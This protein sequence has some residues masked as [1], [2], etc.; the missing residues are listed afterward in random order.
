MP[1]ANK[2]LKLHN[3]Q[4]YFFESPFIRLDN[5]KFDE[6]KKIKI[7]FKIFVLPGG[8]VARLAHPPL[9]APLKITPL[10]TQ[11]CAKHCSQFLF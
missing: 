4:N 5:I 9:T 11:S 10:Q 8:V 3:S 7:S 1:T 6:G 2:N